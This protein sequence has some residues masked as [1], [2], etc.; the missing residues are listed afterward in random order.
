MD[1]DIDSWPTGCARP[2]AL[3]GGAMGDAAGGGVTSACR[4]S[5][6]LFGRQAWTVGRYDDFVRHS[7]IYISI[8]TAY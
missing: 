4:Y 8:S 1:N 7:G 3:I 2:A 5:T 6:K